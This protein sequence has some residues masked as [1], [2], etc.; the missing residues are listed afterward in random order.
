MNKMKL[1]TRVFFNVISFGVGLFGATR[2]YK[3]KIIN[4]EQ[5]IYKFKAYYDLCRKWVEAKHN[6]N[7]LETLLLSKG[8]NEI[9]IYGMGDLGKLL[10]EDLK[11]S[12]IVVKYGIDMNVTNMGLDIKLYKPT[13]E[14][15]RVDLIIVT[16]V[17]SYDAINGMLSE[18][19]DCPIMALDDLIYE[20]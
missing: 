12:K 8:Y 17:T 16:P 14:L 2:M 15:E 10:F 4:K 13:C 20:L 19:V 5:D 6:D 9:A 7:S 1:V 3:K 11:K 18:I